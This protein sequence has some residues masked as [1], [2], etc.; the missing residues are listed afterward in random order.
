MQYRFSDRISGLQPSVIREILK[1]T[2]DPSM[3]SFA[4]GNPSSDAFPDVDI[5]RI[6][7]EILSESPAAALQYS[8]SEGY[9]PLREACKTL[10]QTREGI[11]PNAAD[12]LL[13]LS[14]AQQGV[15]LVSKVL[16]NEGDVVLCESPTFIGSLNCFR[17]YNC[18]LIGIEMEPDGMNIQA[19]EQA[20]RQNPRA[21]LIYTIPNF[22]N[23]T[24]ITTS[25]QKRREILRVAQ[26][27]DL[28]ILEDNPYGEL[29][30]Q[31]EAVASIKSMDT[32]G[33]VIYVGS[34]SKVLSPGMRLGFTLA[35]Q[36]VSAK[37][38]V[39]KQCA[40]V[41]TNILAQMIC[42]RWLRSCDVDA[43][44]ER[45]RTLYRD[46]C[47]LMCTLI[48]E[49]FSPAV[50]RTSPTGG[51]FLWCTLPPGA[52]MLG[53][54]RKAVENRVAVV[55]GSA[56]LTDESAQC[57]SFRLTFSTPTEAQI[58]KGIEILGRMTKELFQ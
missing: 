6:A 31:G 18:K 53:F 14:G 11:I 49:H 25:A 50:T 43:H 30:F 37:M 15:D 41:H 2:S 46:K 48:D 8:V 55:P 47:N 13:V 24:G 4:A 27:N 16:L 36:P 51:L 44:I 12:E 39:G 58:E 38:A 3:I 20:V 26:E 35:P 22:Q 57:T 7:G 23:P 32:Q 1:S 45:M 34:F 9:P 21:R 33:N 52:D 5:A 19:L 40:D 28:M 54:C 17:S 29:R 42:D 10:L 56:F